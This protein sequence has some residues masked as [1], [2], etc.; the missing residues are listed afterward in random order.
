[1]PVTPESA[2]SLAARVPD[3]PAWIDLK[4][5]LLSGRCDLWAESPEAGFVAASRD[6]PFAALYGRPG[7][8]SIQRAAAAGLAAFEGVAVDDGWQLL[9]P[10][11]ARR[12]VA[13]ALP[14][15]RRESIVVHRW[16]GG[17]FPRPSAPSEIVLLA[18]G[19]ASARLDFDAFPAASRREL[20]LDWVRRRPMAVAMA[21][22]R[23]AAYCWA[24]F[25]TERLWD[26]AVETAEPYRRRG[27]AGA[28]FLL[29][30]RHLSPLGKTPTWGAMLDNRASLGLAARL[31]FVRDALLDGWRP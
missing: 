23:P 20:A 2:E 4:G 24:A 16:P 14:G 31:G 27:L 30:A 10:P 8:L 29:L 6:F 12:L 3:E 5:L 15:W 17:S 25:E 19:H 11:S 28:C 26:V 21:D 22:G 13:A 7:S 9:A 18:R 1:M